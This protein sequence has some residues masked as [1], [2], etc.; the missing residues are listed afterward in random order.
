MNRYVL[1]RP[2]DL[3]QLLFPARAGMNRIADI[4]GRLAPRVAVPRTRGD[5]PSDRAQAEMNVEPKTVP[6]TRGD[7][8]DAAA[9][10]GIAANR[11]FPARAGMNRWMAAVKSGSALRCSPHARG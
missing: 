5:E 1:S 2:T 6:R 10:F 3:P 9:D 4:A 7:E 11:L 8:P